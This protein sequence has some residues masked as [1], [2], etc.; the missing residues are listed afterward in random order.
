MGSEEEMEFQHSRGYRM[1]VLLR[2]PAEV[3]DPLLHVFFHGQ[4]DRA[5]FVPPVYHRRNT[6]TRLGAVCLF[7]SDPVLYFDE[8][9]SIGWYLLGDDEFWPVLARLTERICADH[10]LRGVAWHG[11]SAGGYVAIRNCLRSDLPSLAFAVGPQN[12]PTEFYFWKDFASIAAAERIDTV[13]VL[14][15]LIRHKTPGPGKMISIIVSDRDY[16]HLKDHIHPVF[17]VSRAL[18]MVELTILENG[19]GH[20]R[21]EEVDYWANFDRAQERFLGEL[22]EHPLE[23]QN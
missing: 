15:Q 13:P 22:K 20:G 23:Y 2:E 18:S 4:L 1:S 21:V 12:D 8:D 3:R 14:A 17:V 10:G 16:T 19:R 6:S 5:A 7:V 9:S 11:P